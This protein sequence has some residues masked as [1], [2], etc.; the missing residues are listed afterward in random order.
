MNNIIT[1]PEQGNDIL[2]IA[3]VAIEQFHRKTF[4]GNR[5]PAV[6]NESI[7]MITAIEKFPDYVASQKA[8]GPGYDYPGI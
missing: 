2:L 3:K 6:L 5:I 8:V 4:E 7:Y 1:I